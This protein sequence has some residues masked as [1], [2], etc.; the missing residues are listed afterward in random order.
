MLE[1]ISRQKEVGSILRIRRFRNR[2]LTNL[3]EAEILS[4]DHHRRGSGTYQAAAGMICH[5][6]P[7]CLILSYL[8]PPLN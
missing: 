5:N 1:K 6:D 2:F 8:P 7:A 4:A 3:S